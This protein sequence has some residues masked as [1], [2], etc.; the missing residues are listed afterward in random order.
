MTHRVMIVK[1]STGYAKIKEDAGCAGCIFS[2]TDDVDCRKF[3]RLCR[4]LGG[5][6]DATEE[7]YVL[8]KLKGETK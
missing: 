2:E 6:V 1:S 4:V 8:A 7:E 5:F 3:H